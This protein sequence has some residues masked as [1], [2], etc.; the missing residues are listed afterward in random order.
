MKKIGYVIT[1]K[2]KNV[3]IIPIRF[4]PGATRSLLIHA[5]QKFACKKKNC[6]TVCSDI[7]IPIAKITISIRHYVIWD[8]RPKISQEL[9]CHIIAIIG[10]I[11]RSDYPKNRIF[12]E[13]MLIVQNFVKLYV[14]WYKHAFWAIPFFTQL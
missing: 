12:Y 7:I 3:L 4:V 8:F 1:P 5:L 2:A 13:D 10:L 9:S 14:I 6:V 11:T